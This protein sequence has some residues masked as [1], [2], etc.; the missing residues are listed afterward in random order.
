VVGD[1]ESR[2]TIQNRTNL[3]S[4]IVPTTTVQFVYVTG[5][6]RNLFAGSQVRLFGDWNSAGFQ[7]SDFHDIGSMTPVGPGTSEDGCTRYVASV[8]LD[9]TQA[10]RTFRWGVSAVRTDGHTVWAIP[11]EVK[12]RDSREQVLAFQYSGAPQTVTYYLTH[13]R[14]LGANRVRTA[15]GDRLVFSLW[16]PNARD[17]KVVIGKIWNSADPAR[18][19]L[20]GSIAPAQIAG[21]YISD[22][23]EGMHPTRGPFDMHPGADGTW[24]TSLDDAGLAQYEAFDH[25]P[26]MFRIVKNDGTVAF[27][28]DLYSRC[29]IGYGANNPKLSSGEYRG[30]LKDL[31]GGV[32]C[33]VVINPELV[34]KRFEEPL[35]PEMEFVSEDAFW[36]DEFVGGNRPPV[37]VEDLII[38]ELHL[39]ALGFGH[40]GSGNL[41]DAI[42]HLD[43]LVDLGVTAVELLP[44][45]EFQAG[46]AGWGYATSHHF[47]IEYSGG[48]RDKFKYF[49]K[50][51]HRRGIA[52]IIDVVYNHFAHE[53]ERAESKYDSNWPDFD[54]Y[55]W[56]E[57]TPFQ[58]PQ[59]DGGY[60]D[61]QSTAP[62]PRYHEEM[63][64]KLFISSAAALLEE[65]HVDGFRVDQTTSIHAYN[66]L[67]ANGDPVS[68]ANIYGGKLLREL[69]RTLRLIRPEV[70]L[71]AEDHSDWDE[72]TKPIEQGGMGFNARWFAEYYHHLIGD[73]NRG[74]DTAKLIYTAAHYGSQMPLAM[75]TFSGRLYDSR[76]SKVVYH[77][78]HDEAG[79]SGGGP[80]FDSYWDPS[81][82]GKQ[83]TSH[84]TIVVASDAA[85]LIG[86]TRVY[87]EAR[88]RFVYGVTVLSAG[89]PMFLFGEE[90]GAQIR[91]KYKY[92]IESREDLHGLRASYGAR[93]FHYYAE[94]NRLRRRFSTLRTQQIDILC[95]DDANR[96][97][98]FRRVD[99]AGDFIIAASLNDNSF[100]RGFVF[101]DLRLPDAGWR[102]IFN[103]NAAEFGGDNLG[104]LGGTPS[105]HQNQFECVLPKNSVLVFQR[106][107]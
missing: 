58:Y 85:P 9:T 69:G 72:V 49:I 50:A 57:G 66:R 43:Y 71:I 19:P 40:S 13:C 37:V 21:G 106:A 44:L 8:R 30:L 23:A 94:I 80:F 98:L 104:N 86:D 48:G 35:F 16:A 38:Y 82:Q 100:D 22:N 4:C 29:Q 95:A 83:Y 75:G 89:T 64:R 46:G 36:S 28:T 34:T 52:V 3:G 93:L 55:Y 91:F 97:L 96:V 105:S 63:V 45:S 81:D 84:R 67:H 61:N 17:V 65:F 76:Y 5:I 41:K 12:R 14:R 101:H 2:L 107:S 56:Y 26:Y 59:A 51:C 68:D 20:A 1:D 47:A 42:A 54:I 7:T 74:L 24:C 92:V 33:S 25:V 27:R 31:D 15:G 99:G 70:L 79:N 87:A 102:E 6:K 78:S 88:C 53:A 90:V 18:T 73:T 103:S 60:V 77:E 39:G 32:S 10:G 11:T 62:A